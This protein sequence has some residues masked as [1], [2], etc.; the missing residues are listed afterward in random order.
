[1]VVEKKK[2]CPVCIYLKTYPEDLV[3]EVN[4]LI[5]YEVKNPCFSEGKRKDILD[6]LIKS[7]VLNNMQKPTKHYFKKHGDNCLIGFV[8]KVE[9]VKEV[10]DCSKNIDLQHHLDNYRKMTV[11]E[12]DDD[13]ITRLKEIKYLSGV[14][15]LQ[16]LFN[17][18]HERSIPK[19]DISSLKQIEDIVHS[20]KLD[21]KLSDLNIN[22]KDIGE[23]IE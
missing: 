13:H 22:I 18:K 15:I 12:R 11:Q 17:N 21:T 23:D 14:I 16:Q 2:P 19:D 8:P 20:L 1:M 6:L 10:F 7:K 9:D 4:N 3:F 5:F